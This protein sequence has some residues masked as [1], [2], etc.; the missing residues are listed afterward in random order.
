L[1]FEDRPSH[2]LRGLHGQNIS[3]GRLLGLILP[4]FE[5]F[6]SLFDMSYPPREKNQYLNEINNYS[7]IINYYNIFIL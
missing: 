4:L 5:G 6:G 3:L 2:D 7:I 1:I